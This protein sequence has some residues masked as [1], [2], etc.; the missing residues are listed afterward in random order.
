MFILILI[1]IVIVMIISHRSSPF[2]LFIRNRLP[3][4]GPGRHV[5]GCQKRPSLPWKSHRRPPQI[6]IWKAWHLWNS[7]L[8][9][10]QQCICICIFALYN[11][12]HKHNHKHHKSWLDSATSVGK[13]PWF[14]NASLQGWLQL[15]LEATPTP[16]DILTN[17]TDALRATADEW[18]S[19]EPRRVVQRFDQPG[20]WQRG[21]S[22]IH[23]HSCSFSLGQSWP[24]IKFKGTTVFQT[25][26]FFLGNRMVKHPKRVNPWMPYPNAFANHPEQCP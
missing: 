2:C 1:V 9:Q 17:V 15:A 16:S 21:T 6:G 22:P 26:L 3:A 20:M 18:I 14:W 12:M 4:S 10:H 24:T 13:S 25:K 5:P 11:L 19:W 23:A 8:H 7:W